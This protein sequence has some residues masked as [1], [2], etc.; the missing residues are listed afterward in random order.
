[1]TD[2]TESEFHDRRANKE[3]ALANAAPV[4][5]E[6][7]S[8]RQLSALHADE[9]RST[10]GETSPQEAALPV[11]AVGENVAIEA[12]SGEVTLLTPEAAVVTSDLLLAR[13]R[14]AGQSRRRNDLADREVAK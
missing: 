13:S 1:M 8:H 9:A 10:G 2:E 12:V 3:K 14:D 4:S 5:V 11:T 6:A 7:I